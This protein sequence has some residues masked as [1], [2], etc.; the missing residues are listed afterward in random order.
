MSVARMKSV[1]RGISWAALL[2]MVL[3]AG[4]SEEEEQEPEVDTMRIV[5][6]NTTVNFAG[7]TCTPSPA[8]VTIPTTGAAVAATFLRDD[9]S[10][11]P[12]VTAGVFELDV[13]P[14]AR[15]TRTSPFAGTISGGQ[16]GQ[17]TFSFS[18]LHIEEQ[19]EDYGPCQLPVTVQ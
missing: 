12:L 3:V 13:E 1:R 16:P 11:D 9:G 4:C 2:G 7:G 15:F 10:P 14:A 19:H 5:I 17:T 18:L 6:G 8:T